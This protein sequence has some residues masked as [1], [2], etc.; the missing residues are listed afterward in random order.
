MSLT[1]GPL[2]LSLESPTAPDTAPMSSRHSHLHLLTTVQEEACFQSTQSKTMLTTTIGEN[3]TIWA[4]QAGHQWYPRQSPLS[5]SVPPPYY[6]HATIRAVLRGN[7]NSRPCPNHQHRAKHPGQL[8]RK[9]F[10]QDWTIHL[11]FGV[12]QNTNVNASYIL[13]LR[14]NLFLFFP[15]QL[16]AWK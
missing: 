2:T 14:I 16:T 11:S 9:L 1:L 3:F 15:N 10:R 5:P 6:S 7:I 13:K 8:P 4:S 12:W